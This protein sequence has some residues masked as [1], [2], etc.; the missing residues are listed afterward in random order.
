MELGHFNKQSFTARERKAPQGKNLQF[1]LLETLKNYT[2]NEKFNPQMIAV[3]AFFLPKLGHFFPIF[4]KGKGDLPPPPSS[5]APGVHRCWYAKETL[6]LQGE[7]SLI[8]YNC[9]YDFVETSAKAL[10]KAIF[11]VWIP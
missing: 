4:K 3:R 5:Y 2:L 6:H 11:L 9:C 1:F 10:S 7:Y 8:T